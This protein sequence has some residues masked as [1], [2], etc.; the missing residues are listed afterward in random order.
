MSVNNFKLWPHWTL[1]A[2][3]SAAVGMGAAALWMRNEPKAE[4]F[5]P[6]TAARLERVDGEV[7]LLRSLNAEG[8]EDRWVEVTPNTPLTAGDRLYA[9]EDSQAGI[10]FTGRNFARLEPDSALDIVSLSDRRTQLA[11]RDGSAIF[12]IG[13]LADDEMFEV[14]T[15]YGAVDLQEPGLYEVGYNDDGGAFVNV[16][17]G[18]AQVVG[19]AGSG[20]ISKGEMLT[21]LGQTAA[22]VAL[23]RIAPEY[24]GGLVNDYYAY[25]YPDLYDGRYSDYNAYLNDPNYYDPYNRYA[26][27]RY[28]PT[29]VP[30]AYDLDRYG[31]WRNLNGYGYAWTPRVDE[32]WA[33]YR[34]GQWMMDDPYGPT[35]V[36]SEPWGYAP[37]HYGRWVNADNRWYWVP[38][39]A[40]SQ[41]V[42]SPALVAFVPMTEANQIGW[43]P[44]APSDPYA[45]VYYD[46]NWQPHYPYGQAPAPEQITNWGVPG[47]L[48]VIQA[49]DFNNFIDEGNVVNVEPARL[50]RVRPVMEPMSVA[51]LR[52]A[53]LQNAVARRGFDLP[54]GLAKKLDDRRVYASA[55]ASDRFVREDL[56]RRLRVEAVPEKQKK[57]KLKFKD[58]RQE[59]AVSPAPK[60]ARGRGQERRAERELRRQ[61]GQSQRASRQQERQLAARAEGERAAARAAER[62]QRAQGERVSMARQIQAQREAERHRAAEV[63]QQQRAVE[64][65]QFEARRQAQQRDA[66]VRAQQQQH[67]E[68]MRV[69]QQQ[70]QQQASPGQMRRQEAPQ[71]PGRAH[72]NPH[73]GGGGGGP[74][75][76]GGN[77]HGG[78]GPGGGKGRGKP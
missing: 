10:A 1:V 3:I 39:G 43:V 28:V 70:R 16:L 44:L 25:Q 19:L 13:Q 12:N 52:Q 14:A 69:Q 53:S 24:A 32:G 2:L 30:G 49:R 46:E 33:P 18:L 17:S 31:D 67:Q 54:P 68:R 38:G 5:S 57:E 50:G 37:Y 60:V 29:S 21:L 62:Q 4:A 55:P 7:G 41:P 35:W 75:K 56:A 66:A 40:D 65:Q 22:Q 77:P 51:M 11:L 59:P 27:Y 23:S 8:Q 9:R 78:G 26:S 20:Q 42:Y 6:P 76:G 63:R 72:G 47:A 73:G 34:A 58:E 71:G 74:Q 15:P 45:P 64:R 48:T 36:S 61:E